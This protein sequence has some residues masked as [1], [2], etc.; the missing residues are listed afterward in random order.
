MEVFRYWIGASP[1]APREQEKD[2]AT[3]HAAFRTLDSEADVE[4]Y[5]MLG[6]MILL[7]VETPVQVALDFAIP[8]T[9]VAFEHR[10][11]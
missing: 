6:S 2:L 3:L 5:G 10:R 1:E 7:K 9:V 11:Y 8:G 4:E